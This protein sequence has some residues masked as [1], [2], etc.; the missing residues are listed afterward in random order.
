[1]STGAPNENGIPIRMPSVALLCID[2][3]DTTRYNT[4]GYTIEDGAPAQI[5]IN[6]QAP[7]LFGYM[8][9]IALTEVNLAWATPNV[10]ERNNTLTIKVADASGTAAPGN[11][12]GI[13]RIALQEDF[14]LPSEIAVAVENALNE[15]TISGQKLVWQ[16]GHSNI[17]S[18]F[19]ITAGISGG[20]Q[21]YA[22]ILP[23][24]QTYTIINTAVG[25][26]FGGSA[27]PVFTGSVQ[28]DL[29][30]MMGLTPTQATKDIFYNE[31]VSGYASCQ[32]TPYVDI[33]SSILTKN[34]NVRDNDSALRNGA[35]K[36][37]RIYLSHPGAVNQFTFNSTGTAISCN[38]VGVRPCTINKEFQTPKVISWNT[39]ENVDI[40][41]LQVL[42]RLGNP[43]YIENRV[44][45]SED[46]LLK[47]G[48][49][50]TFQFT[51][52]ASE[53]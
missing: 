42:D 41:D 20:V 25:S 23:T 50:A 8:T 32:Y 7:L 52:Q 46:G 47:L 28:D 1:M 4:Q 34:Q 39:T 11:I 30:Y 43:I 48:N 21:Y 33:V 24:N 19:T 29:T 17:A 13:Y 10:N 16:V 18:N 31:I 26:I 53:I 51:V 15:L 14:Y 5:Q 36:L 27:E 22:S 2:S 6:K 35:S 49:T 40:V 12:K 3:A 37:A 45:V 9:R 38:I 44:I